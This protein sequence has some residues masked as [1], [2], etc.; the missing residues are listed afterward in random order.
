MIRGGSGIYFD[1]DLGTNRIAERRILG[2]SG[3]GRVVI[4]GT[5]IANPLFGQTGQPTTL[6]P[7]ATPTTLTGQQV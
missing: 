3:N 6:S 1:S 5:G 4:N 2:P 7:T